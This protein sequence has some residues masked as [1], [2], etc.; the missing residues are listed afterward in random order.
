MS[1]INIQRPGQILDYVDTRE[2]LVE[3]FNYIT[4]LQEE[5]ERLT[6]A[7]Y[8]LDRVILEDRIDKAIELIEKEMPYVY[9]IDDYNETGDYFWKTYKKYDY[10][11]LLD[12]LGGN[13]ESN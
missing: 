2:H 11:R 3:L 5:N 7:R 10:K 6:N 12:I 13:N 1:E 9:E 4:N 8:S